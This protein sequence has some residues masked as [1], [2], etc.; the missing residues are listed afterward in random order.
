MKMFYIWITIRCYFAFLCIV[1]F[2]FFTRY[3]LRYLPPNY[4]FYP[5]I[6][7]LGTFRSKDEDDYEYEFS[8]LNMRTS[9]NVGLQTLCACSVLKPRTR[10][11]PHAPISSDK[12][13]QK[14]GSA[15]PYICL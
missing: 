7:L 12:C 10:S 5:S 3:S 15:F 13:G 9:K 2:V 4:M 14:S 1:I 8:V 6:K 11:R